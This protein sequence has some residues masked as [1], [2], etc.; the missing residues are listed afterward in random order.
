MMMQFANT[1]SFANA[2]SQSAEST[3]VVLMNS[4]IAMMGEELVIMNSM[5]IGMII[6]VESAVMIGNAS[7]RKVWKVDRGRDFV[8]P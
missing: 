1:F 8:Y 2:V 3:I 6:F 7:L 5:M 4:D